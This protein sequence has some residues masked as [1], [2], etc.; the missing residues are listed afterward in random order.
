LV[1]EDNVVVSAR[2]ETDQVVSRDLSGR[3]MVGHAFTNVVEPAPLLIIFGQLVQP[4]TESE[5]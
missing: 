1:L 5:C 3:T 4:S 2:A